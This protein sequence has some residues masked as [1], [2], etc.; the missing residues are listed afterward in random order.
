MVSARHIHLTKEDFEYLFGNTSLTKRNDLN[1]IGK[2]ASNE[3][4]NIIT[5]KGR[6]DNVTIVGPLRNYTQLEISKTDAYKLGLNPPIRRS[7]DIN[8]SCAFT[9]EVNGK[10]L[11]KDCG[12]I[13]PDRHIHVNTKDV[14]K[15][16]I[17]DGDAV[18]VKISGEKGGTLDNV[19]VKVSDDGYYELHIDV[20]DAN[21]HLIKNGDEGEIL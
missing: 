16:G 21:A 20:D 3:K 18:S 7:G 6:F 10:K 17:K 1:Q 11:Y 2:F 9:I 13:I 12:C 5:D 4:V 8:E 15:Y 14:N 19:C